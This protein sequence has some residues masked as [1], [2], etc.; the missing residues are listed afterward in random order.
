MK[1]FAGYTRGVLE[2]ILLSYRTIGD[3]QDKPGDLD[4]IKK[5]WTRIY[6]MLQSISRRIGELDTDDGTYKELLERCRYYIENYYFYREIET[7]SG[8]Y[9]NDPGRIKNIRLEIIDSLDDHGFMGWIPDCIS[10]L[11]GI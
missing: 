11:E 6:G 5:E 8:L 3:L 1:T 4:V 10:R 2:Q 7:I 9:A